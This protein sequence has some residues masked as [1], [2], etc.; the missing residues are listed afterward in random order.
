MDQEKEILTK[1][2][3]QDMPSWPSK[4]CMKIINQVL[5]VKI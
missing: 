2:E 4:D 3:V 1:Q 5:V